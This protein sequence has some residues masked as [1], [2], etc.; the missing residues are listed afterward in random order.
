MNRL[1][2]LIASREFDL[3]LNGDKIK[4]T[5]KRLSGVKDYYNLIV[6]SQEL[7]PDKAF[8]IYNEMNFASFGMSEEIDLVFVDWNNKV[9][10]LE[11]NFARNKISKN[12]DRTKFIYIFSKGMIDKKKIRLNDILNHH[13][14]RK[15]EKKNR[16]F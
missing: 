2:K 1:T 11:H 3:K 15:K 4:I 16:F 6:K 8:F 7:N 12:H 10:H 13:Y 14:D 9:F 5:A